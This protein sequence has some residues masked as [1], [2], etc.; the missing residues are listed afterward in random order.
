MLVNK[1]EK[2]RFHITYFENKEDYFCKGVNIYSDTLSNAAFK[3]EREIK[4]FEIINI[5]SQN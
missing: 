5:F 4:H 3:F 2:I 1:K